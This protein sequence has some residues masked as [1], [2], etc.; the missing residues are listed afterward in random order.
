MTQLSQFN[1]SALRIGQSADALRDLADRISR[2]TDMQTVA[3][4]MDDATREL[5]TIH[6]HCE[7]GLQLATDMHGAI[8]ASDVTVCH[9]RPIIR[10]PNCATGSSSLD[11]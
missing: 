11:R 1:A 10:Q 6:R 5:S 3:E 8:R 4:L 9:Q 7:R 2:E